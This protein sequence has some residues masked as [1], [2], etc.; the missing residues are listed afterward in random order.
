MKLLRSGVIALAV[1]VTSVVAAVADERGRV[2]REWGYYPRLWDGLYVGLHGGWGKSDPA[3]GLLGG[4]Q[5]GYN[6]QMGPLIYGLEADFS[7][8]DIGFSES[9]TVCDPGLGC[10]SASVNG[11]ID[12]M[13]TVRGRAGYLIQPNF[14]F[15]GTAGLGIA[16]GSASASVSGFGLT[17]KAAVTDT[18]WDFVYGV[19]IEGKINQAMTLRIEYL[20]FN[21]LEIDVVRAGLNFKLG[22]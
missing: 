2:T 14:L 10:V 19:G 3:D 8:S 16:H 20:S 17:E 9:G 5:L 18:E 21:D 1:L 22:H 4:A 7:I 11:S 15:Y 12:W 13:A 6:W